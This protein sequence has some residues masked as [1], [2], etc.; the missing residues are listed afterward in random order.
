MTIKTRRKYHIRIERNVA[1]IIVFIDDDTSDE[2]N[3]V[4]GNAGIPSPVVDAGNSNRSQ[5][6]R[7]QE[8]RLAASRRSLRS[9]RR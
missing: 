5:H 1:A 3:N 8:Q 7:R 2:D 6:R 9:L 4:C